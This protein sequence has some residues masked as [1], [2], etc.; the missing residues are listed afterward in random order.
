MYRHLEILDPCPW[1]LLYQPDHQS[2]PN[3]HSVTPQIIGIHL[4]I[5]LQIQCA[6]MVISV[7]LHYYYRTLLTPVTWS[8]MGRTFAIIAS[9]GKLKGRYVAIL[10]LG[11]DY[12]MT[13][14]ILR[15]MG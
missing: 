9:I 12:N 14:M 15:K 4:W 11:D 5:Y 7:M 1:T 3:V 6:T 2:G 10:R 13:H 8:T